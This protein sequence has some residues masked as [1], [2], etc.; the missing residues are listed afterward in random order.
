MYKHNR[1][2]LIM[3]RMDACPWMVLKLDKLFV[4]HSFNL[5]SMFVPALLI[6]W[7]NFGSQVSWVGLCLFLLCEYCLATGSSQDSNSQLIGLLGGVILIDLLESSPSQVSVKSLRYS[8]PPPLHRSVHFPCHHSPA[9]P[10]PDPP[11]SL[12]PQ[13]FL[14][15]PLPSLHTPP[16]TI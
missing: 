16:R 15:H 1:V 7:T 11:P 9:L 13:S 14:S 4:V 10:I 6:G 2:S 3:S 5:C 8:L 12:P